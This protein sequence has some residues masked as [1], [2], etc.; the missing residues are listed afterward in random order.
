M[1]PGLYSALSSDAYHAGPG[2]SKSDLSLILRSP[3]HY[4]AKEEAKDTPALL[5]GEAFHMAILEPDRYAVTYQITDKKTQK[6]NQLPREIADKIQAMKAHLMAHETA[7]ELLSGDIETELSAFWMDPVYD[8][9]LCKARLD[10]LNKTNQTIV[11]L[12]TCI[13]ARPV[14]ITRDAHKYG[15]HCQAFW[16]TYGLQI[17]SKAPHDFYFVAIEKEPPWAVSVYKAS[18]EFIQEGGVQCQKALE[19]YTDCKKK[20]EWP[21]YDE[22]I[23]NLKLPGWVERKNMIDE[24]AIFD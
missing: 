1:D 2:V 22:E 6:G 15:W 4:K 3:S 5:F 12:K 17:L 9:V 14:A 11:D 16:Y 18:P 21:G 7:W 19:I 23:K 24:Y 8:D 20:E 10:V 13:D